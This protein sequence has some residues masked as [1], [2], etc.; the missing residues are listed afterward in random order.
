MKAY[1]LPR[2]DDVQHP[3][4]ADI[5]FYGL[6]SCAGRISHYGEI[7]SCFKKSNRKRSIRRFWKRKAR[8]VGKDLCKELI[9]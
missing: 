6:K 5:C 9:L 7:R 3:D 1:G 4:S 2:N 8:K